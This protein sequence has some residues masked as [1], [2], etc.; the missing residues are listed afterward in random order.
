MR[1]VF[2]AVVALALRAAPVQAGIDGSIDLFPYVIGAST[3]QRTGPDFGACQ[4]TVTTFLGGGRRMS[5]GVCARL[6]GATLAGIAGAGCYLQGL[7]TGAPGQLPDVGWSVSGPED[8]DCKR[9]P[10]V[11]LATVDLWPVLLGLH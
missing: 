4:V 3:G 8:P 1:I 9:D 5:F 11:L 10:L 7:E 6:S 2:A